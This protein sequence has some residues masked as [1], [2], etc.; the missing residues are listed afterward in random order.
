MAATQYMDDAT[1]IPI[2]V[3]TLE[4][5]ETKLADKLSKVDDEV[6]KHDTAL[7]VQHEFN[8]NLTA[9][10]S[11]LEGAVTWMN[12][13]LIGLCLTIA[14]SAALVVYAG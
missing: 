5:N 7:A 10:V 3:A 14:G 13:S 9:A 4:R 8:L 1:A 2:R 6:A 12:R 11:K